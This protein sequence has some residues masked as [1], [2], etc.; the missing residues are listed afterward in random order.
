[1]INLPA[2]PGFSSFCGVFQAL[3]I[4]FPFLCVLSF[5]RRAPVR[6][7][8]WCFVAGFALYE[9]ILFLLGTI[10]GNL[11]FLAPEYYR[12]MYSSICLVLAIISVRGLPSLISAVKT[13]RYRPSWVDLILLGCAWNTLRLIDVSFVNDWSAGTSSFDSL[14]YHIPRALNWSW[15]GSFA[16]TATNIWQ[17]LG[18][19]YGGAATLLPM[20]FLGCGWLGGA[21]TTII[22]S[23]GAA[24]SIFMI[25]RSL[26]FCSRAGWVA[27]ML[28]LSCPVVGW[29]LV[30]TSTDIA[31]CFPVL[32]AIALVRS[33]LSIRGAVFT[34]PLLVGVGFAIK[35]YVLF[36]AIPAALALFAPRIREI[37]TTRQLVLSA[38]SGTLSA[39]LFAFLSFFPIYQAFGNLSGDGVAMS[40]SNI[41]AGWKS[42]WDSLRLVV[43]EWTFEPLQFLPPPAR[44]GVFE[45]FGVGEIFTYFGFEGYNR[46]LSAPDKERCRAGLL[47]LLFLPWLI[48]SFDGWKNRIM[49]TV[50]FLV[51]FFAQF[52]PLSINHVGARFAII[53][54][55]AF[56]V[57]FG[58]RASKS[59]FVTSILLLFVSFQTLRYIPGTGFLDGGRVRFNPEHQYNR[60]LISITQGD[61]IIL[62]GRSLS[63]DAKI[64]GV[65]G[66]VKFEYFRCP[67]DSNWETAFLEA[68]K[69]S[70]WIVFA[71]PEP[72][73]I[74]G[75]QFRT[76]LGPP[77]SRVTLSD[78]KSSLERAG[79]K[80]HAVIADYEI[81]RQ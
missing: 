9:V 20:T 72:V 50:G 26:G 60:E 65:L 32:A 8:T 45:G 31:A 6:G 22:F 43:L 44:S 1:M 41:G 57:L 74:P 17:Q 15:Q 80:Y 40:L 11:G 81:W 2:L 18:H 61:P 56:C 73:L 62:V 25:C 30:D 69:R 70:K 34:F 54:V 10:L 38:L 7:L 59:P 55:G 24:L 16:P 13:L 76:A 71:I 52:A 51:I 53:P 64:A 77:C 75:A 21:Y 46:L 19:P 33:P 36:P 29:R 63:Q 23:I 27:A 79:W 39:L 4:V 5:S 35:Q 12:A 47:T 14:N 49:A 66:E 37:F 42:V 58:A 48:A 3:S 28:F 67:S 78:F 68:K